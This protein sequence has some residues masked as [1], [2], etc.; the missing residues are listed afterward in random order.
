M[1]STIPRSTRTAFGAP[2]MANGVPRNSMSG[3]G[4]ATLARGWIEA[5]DAPRLFRGARAAEERAPLV[6]ATIRPVHARRAR[7]S[8][9]A[10][11]TISRSGVA[12]RTSGARVAAWEFE[13]VGVP[14]PMK[15]LACRA[16]RKVRQDRPPGG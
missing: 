15:A 9:R 11:A 1:S 16:E 4:A 5:T 13:V 2:S 3:R 10:T 7:A 6:W 8:S 12:M 14:P